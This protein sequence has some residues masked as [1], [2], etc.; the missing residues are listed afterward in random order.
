MMTKYDAIT[1]HDG[2]PNR[3]H[4]SKDEKKC[5]YLMSNHDCYLDSERSEVFL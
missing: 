2:C 5:C 1:V 4:C 3:N